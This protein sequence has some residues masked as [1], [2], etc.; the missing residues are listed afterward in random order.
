M[1]RA[2]LGSPTVRRPV[3]L[4]HWSQAAARRS[5]RG[6]L[7]SVRIVSPLMKAPG[8]PAT[9]R[10][11]ASTTSTPGASTSTRRR[12]ST[13]GSSA[14]CTG[15]PG[16]ARRLEARPGARGA[17]APRPGGRA[18]ARARRGQAARRQASPPSSVRVRARLCPGLHDSPPSGGTPRPTP[19]RLRRA[20]GSLSQIFFAQKS[21][22]SGWPVWEREG[23]PKG[24][25]SPSVPDHDRFLKGTVEEVQP[26][27]AR[28]RIYMSG[29]W[30]ALEVWRRHVI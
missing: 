17:G 2:E 26:M 30:S 11:R 9:G 20:G 27:R 6:S 3:A 12:S 24:L 10:R 14:R 23:A 4:N 22:L 5:W 25:R 13:P 28:A 16:A 21:R 7:R 8:C 19:P 15:T 18:R 29:E 1:P